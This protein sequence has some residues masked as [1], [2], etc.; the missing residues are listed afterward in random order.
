MGACRGHGALGTGCRRVTV[1]A[2]GTPAWTP[3][4]SRGRGWLPTPGCFPGK[5]TKKG[6]SGR[7]MS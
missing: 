6:G 1:P 7:V 3:T 2:A 5:K 4:R